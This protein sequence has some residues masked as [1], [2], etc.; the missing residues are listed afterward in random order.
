MDPPLPV[1]PHVVS[2]LFCTLHLFSVAQL[3]DPRLRYS[4]GD[5]PLQG[6]SCSSAPAPRPGPQGSPEP[7]DTDGCPSAQLSHARYPG[8]P[9]SPL[10]C[11]VL[12]ALLAGVVLVGLSGTFLLVTVN[13]SLGGGRE[14]VDWWNAHLSGCTGAAENKESVL[15]EHQ[16]GRTSAGWTGR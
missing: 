9:S 14:G 13:S 6:P 1:P 2:S 10:S 8:T 12:R 3:R 16:A 5:C 7:C 4:R 11:R 15:E